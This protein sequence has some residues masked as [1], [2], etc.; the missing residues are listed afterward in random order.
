MILQTI[1]NV[2]FKMQKEYDFSFLRKYGKV[3][4][5]FDDQDS[6][7]IC[8]GVEKDNKRYFVKFAG[9]PTAEYTGSTEDAV[10]RIKQSV[11]IYN[12]I[13]HKNLINYLYSEE[14]GNGF[15][16]IYDW[17]D[18]K[19]MGRMYV[20]N[21]ISIMNL[22]ICD[23]NRIFDAI[24]NFIQYVVS[25]GYVAVD[26][27]DGSIMYDEITQT[28]TICDIDFF[29]KSPYINY[30]GKMWGSPRFISPEECKFGATIDET[31][32]VFTIGQM[33]F[34]LYTD[35]DRS[36]D[37]WP[38]SEEKFNVLQKAISEN[39]DERFSSINDFCKAWYGLI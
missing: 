4:K 19:C 22:P 18:G 38:L 21:H 26:F 15:A 34:S 33:A 9:A 1:D 17:A 28:V 24:L 8:F 37:A 7:N 36:R 13:R 6:G 5:V 16:I 27:Y 25:V 20:E 10:A 35:S 2:Q 29:Q 31:T 11:Q 30:T 39:R 3:F 23:K 32:N 14:I 12:D